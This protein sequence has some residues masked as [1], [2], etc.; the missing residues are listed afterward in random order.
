M[1]DKFDI[2]YV[3]DSLGVKSADSRDLLTPGIRGYLNG[4]DPPGLQ[5]PS[6]TREQTVEHMKAVIARSPGAKIR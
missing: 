1:S 4:F 5:R 6:H 2:D 3:L